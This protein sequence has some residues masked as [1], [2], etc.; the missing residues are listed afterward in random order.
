MYTDYFGLADNPFSITPDPRFLYLSTRHAEALAHLLYGMRESDGFIQLTGEVGT[1]KTTLIR[2]LLE[3]APDNVDV[4]LILNPRVTMLEFLQTICQELHVDAGDAGSAKQLIDA[5]NE[6]LL[7]SHAAGRRTVL[8]VDEAQNLSGDVLEQ[9]RLLTNLETRQHK[10]LQIILIGQPELRDTLARRDLRQLAQRIT[11][12]YHLQPLSAAETGRYIAHRLEVAGAGGSIFTT[13]AVRQVQRLSGG[14]PRLINVICERALLGAYTQERR[15]VDPRTVRRAASEVLGPPPARR[16]VW[17]WAV[18]ALLLAALAVWLG[19]GMPLPRGTAA[20]PAAATEDG[21]ASWLARSPTDTDTAMGTLFSLWKA[22]YR[23]DSGATACEQARDQGLRCI[24]RHGTWNTLRGYDRP[25]VI[26]LDDDAGAP[27]Q[28]VLAALDRDHVRLSAGTQTRPATTGTLDR[29]WNGEFLLLWRPAPNADRTLQK[30]MQGP[31][32]RW[33]RAQL[34]TLEG[35]AGAPAP[36]ADYFDD[37]LA[38]QVKRFQAD[39]QLTVDGIA[40]EQTLVE[41]NTAL[42][43][44]NRPRLTGTVRGG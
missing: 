22:S 18:A 13:G 1:G 27:H 29:Y 21:V 37:S 26:S 23:P 35:S 4:A 38:G 25:A 3:Q 17:P 20:Q 5:L 24:Y 43:L 7:A 19:R 8:I 40:G 6:H 15:Q 31:G 12:R 16:P 10:L 36:K 44:P 41:L 42:G 30:G 9:V 28:V 2:S 32:V 14:I 39:H 33:L 34:T 11:A